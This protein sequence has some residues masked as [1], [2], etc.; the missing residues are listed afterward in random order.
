MNIVIC[1]IFLRSLATNEV[2]FSSN[3]IERERERERA[4]EDTELALALLRT[5]YT[6]VLLTQQ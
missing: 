1:L 6:H 4:R 5:L 3:A 2:L